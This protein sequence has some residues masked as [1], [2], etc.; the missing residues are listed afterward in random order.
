MQAHTTTRS[1]AA[2]TSPS[3][4][5]RRARS[6]ARRVALVALGLALLPLLVSAIGIV[7]RG[8]SLHPWGDQALLELDVRDVGRHFVLTGAYSRYGW[9]HPGPFEVYLLALPYRLVGERSIGIYLGALLVNG[10]AIVGIAHVARRR[11]GTALVVWSMF[12]T[13]LLVRTF[14][15][16]AV[17][18]P[19]TPYAT[20]I[21]CLLMILLGWSLV[22]GDAWSLPLAVATGSFLVQSHIEYTLLVL[23]LVGG[24]L[25][26][27]LARALAEAGRP[28]VGR[29]VKATLIAAAV[30][31][32]L[33][34]PPVVQQVTHHPGNLGLLVRFFRDQHPG[35]SISTALH[36]IAA[37]WSWRP[38]WLVHWGSVRPT[39]GEL[40]T[41]SAPVPVMLAVFLAALAASWRRAPSA[42]NLLLVV[43]A[44]WAVAVLSVTHIV[45]PLYPY[46]LRWLDALGAATWL[47]VGWALWTS[48]ASV[49]ERITPA[50]AAIVAA[51]LAVIAIVASVASARAPIPYPPE[52]RVLAQIEKPVVAAVRTGSGVVV[53]RRDDTSYAAAT[54]AGIALELERHH[55]PV[56]IDVRSDGPLGALFT[57]S[58]LY[59]R[60]RVRAMLTVTAGGH[61]PPGS[62]NPVAS[63]DVISVLRGPG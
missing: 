51:G 24:G 15:P 18:N 26:V 10:A 31:V 20:V 34:I 1:R 14:G 36:V 33:W 58:R 12:V 17:R 49:R 40:D 35:H 54:L 42:R 43:A 7:V 23:V 4:S 5:T 29:L 30:G 2:H 19:W 47:A 61:V 45:G 8:G 52:S 56:R 22:D 27:L 62:G 55:V 50:F 46:L 3:S 11:A 13:L 59:G 53:L 21:P 38:N 25:V 41:A 63:A 32:V 39:T 60:E 44:S 6:T 9:R 57:R 48:L 16:N 28:R 37:E